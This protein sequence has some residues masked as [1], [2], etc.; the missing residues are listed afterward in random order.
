V[1]GVIMVFLISLIFSSSVFASNFGTV[2][3][4]LQKRAPNLPR[5]DQIMLAHTIT[6]ISN[7]HKIN[8]RLFTAILIQESGLKLGAINKLSNDFGISQINHKTAK[9]FGFDKRRL[10]TNLPYSIT[11]G[12]IVLA[13]FKRM[14]AKGD[15]FY[16]TRYNTSNPE[17]REIYKQLVLRYW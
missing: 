10:L 1:L 9:H 5:H 16:W 15:K 2:L 12:A 6:K 14:Y 13:D 4:Q 8:A 11:A 7:R 17:K 3:A